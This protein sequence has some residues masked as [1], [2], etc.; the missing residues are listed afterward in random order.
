[1]LM[2]VTKF[3]CTGYV[4]LDSRTKS[5]KSENFNSLHKKTKTLLFFFFEDPHHSLTETGESYRQF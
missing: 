1:M 3:R 2:Y 5:E 4:F